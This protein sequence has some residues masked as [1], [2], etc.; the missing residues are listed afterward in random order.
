MQRTKTKNI[1]DLL[2]RTFPKWTESDTTHTSC[3][4]TRLYTHTHT[5]NFSFS[6]SYY[7]LQLGYKPSPAGLPLH[8][9]L[10]FLYRAQNKC[11]MNICSTDLLSSL[12]GVCM[13]AKLLKSCLTLC[14]PLNIAHQAPLSMGISRQGI[15]LIWGSNPYIL[16]LLHWQMGSLSLTPSGKPPYW[17]GNTN[18]LQCWSLYW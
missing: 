3:K 11:I 17:A 16:H 12:L 15:L 18:N 9:S 6:M 14:N 1:E 8:S 7:A 10:H 2:S 13:H 5:H 4:I